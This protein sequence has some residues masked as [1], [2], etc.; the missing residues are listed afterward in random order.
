MD[1][2]AIASEVTCKVCM[3]RMRRKVP[4]LTPGWRVAHGVAWSG[5]ADELGA[6]LLTP[7]AEPTAPPPPQMTPA[8]WAASCK[9]AEHGRCRSDL[10]PLCDWDQEATRWNAVAPWTQKAQARR[11]EGSPRWG[12]VAAALV[13]LAE[14][15]RHGRAGK[16]AMGGILAR[17]ELGPID[18][19]GRG[20]DPVMRR[21]GELVAVR[22]A[23]ELAYPAG[24]HRVPAGRLMA[25]LMA[26]TPGVMVDMP[27]Y[28]DLAVELGETVGELRAL[29]RTGRQRV[30]EALM[31]RGLVRG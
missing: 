3:E 25:L 24:G 12:S 1:T 2:T 6:A 4:P 22:Q 9:G 27:T 23:L 17:I 26:R 13:E 15:E 28:D 18:G 31:E 21:G 19:I 29:V 14:Y 11:P 8:L 5:F 16:S 10:C 7:D 30:A 20:D